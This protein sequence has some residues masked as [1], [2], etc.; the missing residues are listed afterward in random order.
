VDPDAMAENLKRHLL[1]HLK[2]I[3]PLPVPERLKR[4]Y[5]KYRAQG[6]FLEKVQ[7]PASEVRPAISPAAA[8]VM[9]R[10]AATA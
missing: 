6:Q 3:L 9:A 5:E 1:K 10:A 2:E 7:P 4:R 8:N